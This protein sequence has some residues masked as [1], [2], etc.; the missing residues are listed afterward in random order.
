MGSADRVRHCIES[1]CIADP[2]F[3]SYRDAFQLALSV[4]RT[5]LCLRTFTTRKVFP[6]T[7]SQSARF[8]IRFRAFGRG[9]WKT[10]ERPRFSVAMAFLDFQ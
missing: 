6:I 1:R 8:T 5:D 7:G 3:L 9:S 10:D 4:L 2:P